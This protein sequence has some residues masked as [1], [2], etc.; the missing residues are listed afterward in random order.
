M[1]EEAK[2]RQFQEQQKKLREFSAIGGRKM[3]ADSLIQ[4][5]MGPE[6]QPQRG[7]PMHQQIQQQQMQQQQM[8][9]QQMQQ[10]QM[11]QHQNQQQMLLQQQQQPI[12]QMPGVFL[13]SI[14]S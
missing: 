3:D 1:E 14:V 10:Q 13:K 12:Q 7:Q 6:Q 2:R 8:Q 4:S 5:I 11:Q 9:Q